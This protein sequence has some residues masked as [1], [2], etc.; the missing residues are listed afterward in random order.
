[1]HSTRGFTQIL[2]RDIH[3]SI[4]DDLEQD[5]TVRLMARPQSP[6]NI[7]VHSQVALT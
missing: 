7:K 4:A 6:F 2:V 1:M 3:P 5:S